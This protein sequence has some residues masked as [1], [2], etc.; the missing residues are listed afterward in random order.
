MKWRKDVMVFTN[1]FRAIQIVFWSPKLPD[2][3]TASRRSR[4]IV[5][6][7]VLGVDVKGCDVMP[8]EFFGIELA[9]VNLFVCGFLPKIS[10][11]MD[12]LRCRILS[13]LAV[14]SLVTLFNF[15]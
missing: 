7:L 15:S 13:I 12:L 14:A 9:S 4:N 8:I 6:Y 5:Y 11:K 2:L 1:K 10:S 3:K